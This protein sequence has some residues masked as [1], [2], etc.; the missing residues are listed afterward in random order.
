[1]L[2]TVNQP[3]LHPHPRQIYNCGSCPA[4]CITCGMTSTAKL[5]CSLCSEH[6]VATTTTEGATCRRLDSIVEPMSRSQSD[7]V[8]GYTVAVVIVT[9]ILLFV[10]IFCVTQM[11]DKGCY[12]WRGDDKRKPASMPKDYGKL[13]NN[14]AA[15]IKRKRLYPYP[16]AA[17][18][19][20]LLAPPLPLL[21]PPL[22][23]LYVVDH[24]YGYYT[25]PRMEYGYQPAMCT[26]PD[27]MYGNP[28]CYS[29]PYVPY[30]PY[31]Y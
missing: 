10:A 16:P 2:V 5:N 7:G 19:L 12:W 29:T 9:S 4:N 18:P 31:Y 8:Y 13:E 30:T 24:D 28:Y 25:Q 21:A 26:R 27:E 6:Y 15:A 3:S 14:A 11:C 17:P 23:H 1:M 20:P 22:P